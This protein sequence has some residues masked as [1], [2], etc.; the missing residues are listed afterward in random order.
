[1]NPWLPPRHLVLS[2]AALLLLLGLTVTAAYLPLGWMNTA[3]ALGIAI[4]KAVIVLAV[5][6]E[7]RESPA[8]TIAFAAAGFLWLSILLWLA[9]ADVLT[10]S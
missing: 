2:Y 10:R 3:V 9:M 5:F 6:M 4:L 8:L 1:M 7:L